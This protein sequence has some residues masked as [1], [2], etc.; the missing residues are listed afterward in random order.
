MRKL[1]SKIFSKK[2]RKWAIAVTAVMFAAFLGFRH[3]RNQRF[4]VPRGIAWGNGRIESK[5]VDIAAKLPLRVE[6]I[7]VA[8]GDLVK[9]GQVVVKMDTVTLQAE[10]AEAKAN[11]AAAQEQLAVANAGIVKKES[12]IELA[13]IEKARSGRLVAERAG[14]QRELDVRIRT[15]KSS[16]AG[17]AEETAKLKV[18]QEQ[19]GVAQANVAKQQ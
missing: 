18:A 15:V 1:L 17:L 5:E 9:P 13:Q 7:L 11:L 4:A 3:W 8:E 14:S 19:V 2:Y 16:A 12:D 6:Q 10:L